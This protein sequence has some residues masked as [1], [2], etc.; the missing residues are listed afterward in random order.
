MGHSTVTLNKPIYLGQTILDNSKCIMYD[1]HYNY[2]KPKYGNRAK[3]LMTDTDS[4]CYEIKTDDFYKDITPGV[5]DRFDTSNYDLNP[6][7]G[8]PSGRNK[9]IPGMMKDEAAGKFVTEFAGLRPKL[10]AFTIQDGGCVKKC[11]GV[12]KTKVALTADDD[13]RFL[14]QNSGHETHAFGH[15]MN[16]HLK[17]LYA[18]MIA[19]K[20]QVEEKKVLHSMRK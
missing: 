16:P 18:L 12:R 9:K 13:K 6:P 17:A 3:L 4:L 14:L 5:E 8:I 20:L 15:W 19:R 1:F 10:Y 7:S 2:L 11:K